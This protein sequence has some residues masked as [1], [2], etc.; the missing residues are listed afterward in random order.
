MTNKNKNLE[1]ISEYIK[2]TDGKWENDNYQG[3]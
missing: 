1:H 2:K 3:L